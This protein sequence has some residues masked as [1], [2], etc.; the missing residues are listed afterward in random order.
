MDGRRG[1]LH[2][3]ESLQVAGDLARTE[4]IPLAQIQDL[5]D[6]VWRRRSGRAGRG[7]WSGG[8]RALPSAFKP[9]LPLVEGLPRNAEM[10]AGPRP[11][12]RARGLLQHPESPRL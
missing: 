11:I 5:A 1:D 10:P 4:V 6:H 7:P 9:H 12:A 3:V 8:L 2:G